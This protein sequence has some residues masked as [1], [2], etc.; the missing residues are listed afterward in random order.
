MV[1]VHVDTLQRFFRAYPEAR[2]AWGQGKEIGRARLRELLW[3]QAKKDPAQARFLAKQRA[4]LG[5]QDNPIPA[6]AEVS[7]QEHSKAERLTRIMELQAK[8]LQTTTPINA[9]TD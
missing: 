2:E 1:Q 7:V 5:Y 3:E 8:V 4:W 6:K 9:E